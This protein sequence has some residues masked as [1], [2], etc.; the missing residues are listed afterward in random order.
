MGDAGRTRRGQLNRD[1]VLHAA[2]DLADL[3]GF[4]SLTMRKLGVALGVE[5]MSLY[6]H[7][8]NKEDLLD[9]MI[10]IVFSEIELPSSEDSWKTAMRKRAIS[11][12]AVLSR[13]RWAIPTLVMAYW[14]RPGPR[15]PWAISK[16][17]PS[18]RIMFSSGTR[19]SWKA[20]S[21]WPPGES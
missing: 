18:P 8:A 7:V 4:D 11:T 3:G 19:T 20:N 9:G 16:P 12:R 15:R 2:V 10:D 13:H 1:R 14:K 5:A 21:P 6:N 17:R